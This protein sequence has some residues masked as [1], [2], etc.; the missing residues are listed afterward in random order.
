MA[1]ENTLW[2][3]AVSCGAGHRH[4]TTQIFAG[5]LTTLELDAVSTVNMV[6]AGL[7]FNILVHPLKSIFLI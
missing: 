7:A 5:H 2:S 6:V 3:L 1:E 4:L